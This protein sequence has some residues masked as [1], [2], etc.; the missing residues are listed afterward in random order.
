[1]ESKHHTRSVVPSTIH[2]DSK[3]SR[4]DEVHSETQ[5]QQR[6]S[7]CRYREQIM[8]L[9]LLLAL[10]VRSTAGNSLRAATW[11]KVWE[12]LYMCFATKVG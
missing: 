5:R 12:L 9:R 1:M 7:T 3:E 2:F 4:D 8:V 10:T 6:C 11:Q